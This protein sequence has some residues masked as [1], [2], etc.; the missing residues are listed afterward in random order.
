MIRRRRRSSKNGKPKSG[1]RLPGDLCQRRLPPL[2]SYFPTP[3]PI[4]Y[5]L[6]ISSAPGKAAFREPGPPQGLPGRGRARQAA[7]SRMR[8]K[9][10]RS[11]GRA[12]LALEK[13]SQSHNF[14][15]FRLVIL[16]H[17]SIPV[18]FLT[19]RIHWPNQSDF[20]RLTALPLVRSPNRLLQLCWNQ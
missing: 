5:L 13:L 20:H 17:G 16:P 4:A 6:F 15:L 2:S 12:R 19:T 3:Q 18:R 14:R 1:T 9:P 11:P 7:P 8:G 10:R